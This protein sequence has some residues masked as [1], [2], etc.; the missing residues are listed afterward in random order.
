MEEKQR[1]Q[2]LTEKIATEGF[3]AI[4]LADPEAIAYYTGY[5]IE[6]M[7]RLWL[8]VIQPNYRPQLIANKLFQFTENPDLDLDI[9]WVD[10][11]T[12]TIEAFMWLDHFVETHEQVK[13]GVD[14]YWPAGQLLP[15]MSYY[16]EAKF[17]L[18][19][20]YVDAQRGIKSEQEQER[21]RA[22]SLINDRVMARLATELLPTGPSE[23]EACQALE[24]YYQEAGA[25]G[26]FSF[27]PIVAYGKNGADPH[28]ESDHTR[29]Q[30]GDAIV[31]DIGCRHQ[32]YASDMTRTFY[33]GQVSDLDRQLYQTCLEA[34]LLGIEASQVGQQFQA[35]DA[36]CRD[37][38]D[39]AGYGENFVHRTGHFIGRSAHEAGD[40]SASNYHPV[41]AGQ[42]FSIEPGIYLSDQTAVRIED[43]V[44]AQAEGPEVINHYP[45]D[46]QII[47]IQDH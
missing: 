19:S 46:L 14:K 32:G 2:Q 40:V 25:D 6:P 38:I 22:A 28:H 47:P 18:A 37:H 17:R 35:I 27:P 10:D 39:Q 16:S 15:V 13:I 45:K 21:M 43:L 12:D 20:L 36:A 26:G 3:A 7:E 42:V 44:I 11:N 30:V 5:E 8:L 9:L 29:P 41:E 23:I 4:I 24:R 34:N 31:V 33:Y 1:I